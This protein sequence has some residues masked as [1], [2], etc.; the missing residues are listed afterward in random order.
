MMLDY[1]RRYVRLG[2]FIFPLAADSKKP[3]KD[4]SRL[5]MA[6]HDESTLRHS[7]SE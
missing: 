2:C 7:W 6:T 5:L 3:I 4:T 1:A